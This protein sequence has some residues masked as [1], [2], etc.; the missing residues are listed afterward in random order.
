MIPIRDVIPTRTRPGVTLALI[1]AMAA[2]LAWPAVRH[3]SFPWCLHAAVLWLFGRTVEDRLGHV[4]FAALILAGVAAAAA[5]LFSIG[6]AATI[7]FAAASAIAGVTA[8]YLVL[9]PRSRVLTLVPVLVGV[10]VT[11]VPAWV[12]AGLW[13][14]VQAIEAWSRAV[15]SG[16]EE[17]IAG[18][19]AVVAGAI[20]GGVA[21]AALRRPER[22]R[23]EWWDL[24]R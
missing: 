15:W 24:P 22:M 17:G 11:D 7:P 3:E 13:A 18:A 20:A 9:F 12:I 23:V 6:S 19:V 16:P 14:V 10:E 2:A 4:R 1:A 21:S 5:A 8:A